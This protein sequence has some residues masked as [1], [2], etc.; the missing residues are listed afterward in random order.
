MP[1]NA[2]RWTNGFRNLPQPLD[3]VWTISSVV[4]LHAAVSR[5]E[6]WGSQS[7]QRSAPDPS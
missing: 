3:V 2:A 5:T 4:L 7:N 6:T 1:V